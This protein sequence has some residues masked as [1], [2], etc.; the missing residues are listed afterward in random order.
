[1]IDCISFVK[2]IEIR[3]NRSFYHEFPLTFRS[4][5]APEWSRGAIRLSV[6][7][8]TTKEEIDRAAHVLWEAYQKLQPANGAE[9]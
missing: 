5:V 4:G 3:N 7:R 9:K 1:M 2:N 8:A 6:G